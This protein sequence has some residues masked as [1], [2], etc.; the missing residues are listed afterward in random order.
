MHDFTNG[1][2]EAPDK[3]AKKLKELQTKEG[4]DAIKQLIEFY[5]SK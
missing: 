4:A 1:V 3:M 5:A 2:R